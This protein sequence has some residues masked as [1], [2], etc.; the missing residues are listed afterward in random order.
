MDFNFSCKLYHTKVY[1]AFTKV[2]GFVSRS[3]AKL[4]THFSD[5]F[6]NLYAFYKLQEKYTKLE[7]FSCTNTPGKIYIFTFMPLDLTHRSS[8]T[9]TL[10]EVPSAAGEARRRRCGPRAGKQMAQRRDWA[11]PLSIDGLGAAA[12]VG[13]ERRRRSN[14]GAAAGVRFTAR[15]GP[16]LGHTWLREPQGVPVELRERLTGS[17]FKRGRSSPCGCLAAVANTRSPASRQFSQGN[18]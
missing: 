7:E 6:V 15:R 11:H 4:V 12:D 3:T 8:S 14:G 2:V 1:T 9:K 13:D 16:A 17:G 10:I 5:F 18:T